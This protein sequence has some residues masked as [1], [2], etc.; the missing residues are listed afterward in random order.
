MV[1]PRQRVDRVDML[2]EDINTPT[3]LL[4]DRQS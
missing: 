3:G 1:L 2:F 4:F